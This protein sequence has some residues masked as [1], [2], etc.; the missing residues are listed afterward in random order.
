MKTSIARIP[1]DL[2]SLKIAFVGQHKEEM[3]RDVILALT[4]PEVVP[5]F[6]RRVQIAQLTYAF[7]NMSQRDQA[8]FRGN[9]A[10]IFPRLIA[11]LVAV[12]GPG[13]RDVVLESLRDYF[14]GTIRS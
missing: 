1:R 8:H 12:G 9:L 6:R 3:A 2:S 10:F 14:E 7:R 11:M 4:H 5:L 13:S